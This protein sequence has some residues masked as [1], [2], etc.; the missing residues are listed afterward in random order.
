MESLRHC[1][2]SWLWRRQGVREKAIPEKGGEGV[3]AQV[4]APSTSAAPT[5]RQGSATQEMLEGGLRNVR[6]GE[7]QLKRQRRV[8]TNHHCEDTHGDRMCPWPRVR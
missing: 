6:E 4:T 7:R 8:F 1:L 5:T 2:M 3:R